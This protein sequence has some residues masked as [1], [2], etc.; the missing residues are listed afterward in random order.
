MEGPGPILCAHLVRK[1]D[2]RLLE[3]LASLRPDEWEMQ[4]VAPVW[5]VRDVAAHLLDTAL[6]KLSAVRDG[7]AVEHTEVRH[8]GEL[9]ALV[10]RWNRE[11]VT[12]YR[13]LSPAVLI[14]LMASACRQSAEF[15]EALDP[16][17]PGGVCGQ[18]GR[19]GH[20]AELVRYGAGTNGTMAS[21]ATN[22]LCDGQIGNY[23][24]GALWS[25][26]RLFHARLAACLP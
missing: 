7:W 8:A 4:T 15:H 3:L 16:F 1:T 14:E 9:A 24:S 12:V 5:Q 19:R 25:G 13:R 22:S 21:S 6:R 2:E 26:A 18:L 23:D 10:N 20:F 11:G 17:A